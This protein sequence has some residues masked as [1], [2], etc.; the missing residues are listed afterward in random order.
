MKIRGDEW[1]VVL[2]L[3]GG[4]PSA[5]Y[6]AYLNFIY[7]DSC[8]SKFVCYNNLE[9]RCEMYGFHSAFTISFPVFPKR[10]IHSFISFYFYTLTEK[11]G[12]EG[13]PFLIAIKFPRTAPC[14]P[15]R[16]KPNPPR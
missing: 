4:A 12:F 3:T 15:W 2:P 5:V 14:S 6:S 13:R 16:E 10:E 8:K 9:D 11:D 7:R 1:L